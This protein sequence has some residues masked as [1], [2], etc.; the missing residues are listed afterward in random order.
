MR[1]GNFCFPP[2]TDKGYSLKPGQPEKGAIF[3]DK[4]WRYL[5]IYAE[6]LFQCLPE[7]F[8]RLQETKDQSGKAADNDRLHESIPLAPR[9]TAYYGD[10]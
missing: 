6:G 10:P 1:R 4:K 9:R 5:R 8:S 7:T 2:T 3:L